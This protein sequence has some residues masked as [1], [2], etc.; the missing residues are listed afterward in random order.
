MNKVVEKINETIASILANTLS[1]IACFYVITS[2]ILIALVWQKPH[3]IIGW[4]QYL[5]A[6]LF[7]GSALP[8]LGYVSKR[9]GD[10]SR[11]MLQ[12]THDMVMSEFEFAKEERAHMKKEQGELTHL[13]KDLHALQKKLNEVDKELDDLE[14]PQ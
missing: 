3:D 12:E 5:I 13:L 6:F 11:K 10:E 2:L 7:Q 4:I 9:E 8:V 14:K 1:S